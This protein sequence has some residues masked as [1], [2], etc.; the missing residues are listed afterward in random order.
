MSADI[1]RLPLAR[2]ALVVLWPAFVM[3]GVLEMLIFVVVDPGGF[4]WFGG[5]PMDWSRQAVYTAT[6]FILWSVLAVSGALTVLFAHSAAAERT[7]ADAL[8]DEVID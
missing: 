4:A 7:S 6:F 5:A 3:A 2:L 8:L 1:G